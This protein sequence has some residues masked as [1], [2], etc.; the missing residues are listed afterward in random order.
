MAAKRKTDTKKDLEKKI[1]AL[2]VKL[3]KL[4]EKLD[5]PSVATPK[6]QKGSKTS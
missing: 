2:E 1:A 6:T 4:S 5:P 3:S